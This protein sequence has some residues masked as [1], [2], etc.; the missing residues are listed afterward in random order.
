MSCHVRA[1]VGARAHRLQAVG[2]RRPRR[3][4]GARGGQHVAALRVA[5]LSGFHANVPALEAA[6]AQVER[7]S[8]DRI[9]IGGD[10][11]PG[12]LPVETIERLRALGDRAVFV[13][14][15]G[16]RWVVDAFDAP[17]SMSEGDERPGRPWAAW[18][19]E[20]I[21][22]RDRDLLASFAERAVLAV[23]GLGPT[24]FC[25]GSPR[26]DEELLTTL[27]P[28]RRWRPALEGV[29][30]SVVVCGHAHAHFD[31]QLGRGGSSTPARWGFRTRVARARTG[32][33]SART[34]STGAPTTTSTA[35]LPYCARAAT[36]TPTSCSSLFPSL[37][38][39]QQVGWRRRRGRLLAAPVS[40]A[41]AVARAPARAEAMST[42]RRL[43]RRC[44]A[45]PRSRL[46]LTR[47]QRVGDQTKP[48]RRRAAAGAVVHGTTPSALGITVRGPAQ[49][50]LNRRLSSHTPHIRHQLV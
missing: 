36:R 47:P 24:L 29:A 39:S 21:D 22:R 27:T 34:S 49:R 8:V 18:T 44:S 48:L 6:L 26:D 33:C 16:D 30:E 5:A 2:G 32:C 31:R 7:V 43:G 15:N 25:H 50:P 17:G 13:R 23:D 42:P 20:A 9:V 19:A 12:P 10:V 11:V 45:S 38:F 14:G 46:R 1:V 4:D 41:R 37:G 28:K 35:P 3:G 40:Q